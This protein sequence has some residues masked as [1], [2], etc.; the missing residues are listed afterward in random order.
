MSVS[1]NG[2]SIS[3]NYNGQEMDMEGML[4]ETIRGI[5]HFLNDL[6]MTL[7]NVAASDDRND[8]FPEIVELT[9]RIEDDVDNMILLFEDLKTVAN[10]IRG[11]TP[12]DMK[13]WYLDHKLKRKEQKQKE[14]AEKKSSV[15]VTKMET[16]QE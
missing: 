1:S 3:I 10:Q 9:D 13:D 16:M 4:D 2:S 11:K 7:R 8:D 15:K 5:Q 14:K 6:Q 12:P